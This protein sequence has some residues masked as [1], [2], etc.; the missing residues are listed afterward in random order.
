MRPLSNTPAVIT[1]EPKEET[2]EETQRRLGFAL[3]SNDCLDDGEEVR[4]R[5]RERERLGLSK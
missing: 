1:L 5:E 3:G 2:L 4:E